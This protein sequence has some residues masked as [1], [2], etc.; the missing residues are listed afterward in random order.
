MEGKMKKS[1]NVIIAGVDRDGDG[2]AIKPDR[3]GH[4]CE[5]GPIG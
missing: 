1:L 3:I 5:G 4:F 2:D